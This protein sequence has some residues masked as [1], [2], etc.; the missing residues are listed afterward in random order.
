[1]LVDRDGVA[2]YD[3]ACRHGR[4][5][6]DDIERSPAHMLVLVRR[7][8]FVRSTDSTEVLFDAT[9]AY[10]VNPEE[11]QRIDH[12]H[13]AG[14]DCTALALAP[15]LVAQLWG[16]EAWLPSQPLETVPALD[17]EH[18]R[19]LAAGR[20]GEDADALV[21]RAVVLAAHLLESANQRRVAAGRPATAAR[22]R[23]LVAGVREALADC[24]DR[25]LSELARDLAT[26]PHHL[27]RT[28]RAETGR[29]IARHRMRLRARAALERL[30]GGE[31]NLAW[32]AAD[33][34]FADQSHL[35]RVLRRET[36]TP[37]SALRASLAG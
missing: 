23:A 14:D 11:E 18:R 33:A 3:V 5:S 20:R 30:V 29:T 32:L 2:V 26:S 27:S 10:A 6:G 36:G 8:C 34:G 1:M 7:G 17:L 22:R 19:L 12:P 24:P 37:P 35:T 16:G 13:D 9:L 4:G 21:E 31:R 15:E 28:F 25:S